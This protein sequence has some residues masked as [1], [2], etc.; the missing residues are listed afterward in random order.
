[1]VNGSDTKIPTTII[2]TSAHPGRPSQ[3]AWLEPMR[4]TIPSACRMMLMA[5]AL[6]SSAQ[7]KISAV[8]STDAAHGAISA[9][10]AARRKGKRWLNSCASAK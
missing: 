6:G 10:R 9:V 4:C 5:P 7:R 1:M 2:Q 8:I 3:S